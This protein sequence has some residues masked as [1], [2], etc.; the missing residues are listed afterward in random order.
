[1]CNKLFAATG[2]GLIKALIPGQAKSKELVRKSCH[3]L[4]VTHLTEICPQWWS[5]IPQVKSTEPC[6][7]GILS[8]WGQVCR[9]THVWRVQLSIL[10]MHGAALHCGPM[11][12]VSSSVQSPAVDISTP[13]STNKA[14]YMPHC[15]PC[16]GTAPVYTMSCLFY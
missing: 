7:Y 8:L 2:K 5:H 12:T 11:L 3:S 14:L 13:S 10:G 9:Y 1:L 15:L 16:E 4:S 6:V